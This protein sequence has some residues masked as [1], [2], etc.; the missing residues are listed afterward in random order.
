MVT[1]QPN[2]YRPYV[3]KWKQYRFLSKTNYIYVSNISP[4]DDIVL[5]EKIDN[6][7]LM[8]ILLI[9]ILINVLV[10]IL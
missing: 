7:I 1:A 2:S 3:N 9:K 8:N 5:V 10:S 4:M 6:N